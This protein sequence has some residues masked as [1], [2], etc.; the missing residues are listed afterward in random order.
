MAGTQVAAFWTGPDQWMIEAPG[1]AESDFAA[2]LRA[3]APGHSV[4]E[5]TDGWV[6]F[7]LDTA[8]A[9]RLMRLT[10]RL[11]DL[12]PERLDIG[13][14]Q[15]T[16]LHHMSV[17]V[18]RLSGSELRIWG[19]RSLAGSLWHALETAALRLDHAA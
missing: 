3:E 4:T 17:F 7:D 12:P 13:S 19:I 1:N 14:A 11:C 2:R 16:G 10:E 9:A 8:S 6:A 15:R 18:L 5:Q